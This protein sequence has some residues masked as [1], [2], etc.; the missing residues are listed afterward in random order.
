[1]AQQYSCDAKDAVW[2]S[3]AHRNRLL[4]I[5]RDCADLFVSAPGS[6]REEDGGVL[7]LANG[8]SRDVA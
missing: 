1:M 6:P 2:K 5:G 7:N 4:G 8:I 3:V